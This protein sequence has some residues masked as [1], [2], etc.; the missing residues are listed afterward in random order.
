MPSPSVIAAT[1][2]NTTSSKENDERRQESIK[3]GLR[4]EG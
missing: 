2:D 4:T 3:K 1:G